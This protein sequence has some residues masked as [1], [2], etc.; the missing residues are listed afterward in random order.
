MTD[1]PRAHF[2]PLLAPADPAR[3]VAYLQGRAVSLA[4]FNVHVQAIAQRLPTAGA[5]LNLCEDRYRFLVGYAAALSV[6]HAVLLPPSRA[7]QVVTEIGNA[8]AGSYRWQDEMLARPWI[9][10][11]GFSLTLKRSG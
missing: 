4:E 7:D 8:N 1:G 9:C 5:M 3:P 10:G 11:S 6:G 2:L